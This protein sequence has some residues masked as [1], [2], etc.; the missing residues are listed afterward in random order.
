MKNPA[1][2]AKECA[3]AKRVTRKFSRMARRTLNGKTKY[4]MRE[5]HSLQLDSLFSGSRSL[6][7]AEAAAMAMKMAGKRKAMTSPAVE[8]AAAE[9]WDGEKWS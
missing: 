8:K 2:I 1:T 4:T 9:K 3:P 5:V 7:E 6:S